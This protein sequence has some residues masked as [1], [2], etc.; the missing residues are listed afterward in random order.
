MLVVVMVVAATKA[1]MARV[2]MVR[3]TYERSWTFYSP[4]YTTDYYSPLPTH[5]SPL[6]TTSEQIPV[7]TSI[8][9]DNIT[10]NHQSPETY[11]LQRSIAHRSKHHTSYHNTRSTDLVRSLLESTIP[12]PCPCPFFC[13]GRY[14]YWTHELDSEM[15]MLFECMHEHGHCDC[16]EMP[17]LLSLVYGRGKWSEIWSLVI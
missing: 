13:F 14:R 2:K 9:E 1:A 5:H 16:L 15:V 11:S 7:W 4:T 3:K 8:F 12:C 17:F 10:D 6:P